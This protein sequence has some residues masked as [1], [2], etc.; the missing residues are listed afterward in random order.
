MEQQSHKIDKYIK[1]EYS[2]SIIYIIERKLKNA[3]TSLNGQIKEVEFRWSDSGF[4]FSDVID[5]KFHNTKWGLIKEET[6]LEKI[7]KAAPKNLVQ[8]FKH[9]EKSKDIIQSIEKIRT[10]S[11]GKKKV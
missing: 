10:L 5:V 7:E 4:D 2:S 11:W 8:A 3:V 9:F 6:I 1:E